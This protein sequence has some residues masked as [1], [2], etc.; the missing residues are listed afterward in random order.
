[1]CLSAKADLD[2]TYE[3]SVVRCIDPGQVRRAIV[4]PGDGCLWQNK[5]IHE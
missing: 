2:N 3:Q 4:V 5:E 1:M